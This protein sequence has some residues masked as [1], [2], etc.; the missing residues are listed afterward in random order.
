M[1]LLDKEF[2]NNVVL[3]NEIVKSSIECQDLVE[4]VQSIQAVQS[5]F[6]NTVRQ[7]SDIP[8]I[9]YAVG[10]FSLTKLKKLNQKQQSLS[11]SNCN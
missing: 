6:K 3:N 7:C 8:G 4:M 1:K 9:I 2:L 11:N 5:T 10:G